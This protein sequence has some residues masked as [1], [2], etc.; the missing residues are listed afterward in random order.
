MI[1]LKREKSKSLIKKEKTG[2]YP[3]ESN[4]CVSLNPW[5][6]QFNS[7][8]SWGPDDQCVVL[9]FLAS[10]Q[11]CLLNS[12][13]KKKKSH[14]RKA[15]LGTGEV[16]GEGLGKNGWPCISSGKR[17]PSSNRPPTEIVAV[18]GVLLEQWN[19]KWL[20]ASETSIRFRWSYLFPSVLVVNFHYDLPVSTHIFATK[21]FSGPYS[22]LRACSK[23]CPY[24]GGSAIGPQTRTFS[25][26]N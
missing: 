9:T 11:K 3:A 25:S 20:L 6:P 21:M 22:Y 12:R 2:K 23:H 10:G 1:K 15:G 26:T 17:Q 24:N 7:P 13:D 5:A 14:L 16:Q 19:V 4:V 8:P 18:C